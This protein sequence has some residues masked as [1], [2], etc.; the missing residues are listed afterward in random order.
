MLDIWSQSKVILTCHNDRQ[1][2]EMSSMPS[3]AVVFQ[4][5]GRLLKEKAPTNA[6]HLCFTAI[7]HEAGVAYSKM[8]ELE[9]HA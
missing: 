6:Q 1:L 5:A 9:E 3:G 4:C 8:D 2:G 7:S